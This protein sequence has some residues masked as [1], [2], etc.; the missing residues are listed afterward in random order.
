[1]KTFLFI[2]FLLPLVS[3]AQKIALLDRNFYHSI[4]IADSITMEQAAKGILP[5]YHRDLQAI[6]QGMQWLIQ[7]ITAPK[8]NKEESFILKMGNSKCIVKTESYRHINNYNIVL[9]TEA[10][11][12]K[13]SIVLASSEPNKRAAQRVAVFMDY[14]RNNSWLIKEQL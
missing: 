11:N 7:Y 5:V 10:N 2:F 4:N 9:N 12:I 14:L 1:M 3:K 13:T 8:I 6:I